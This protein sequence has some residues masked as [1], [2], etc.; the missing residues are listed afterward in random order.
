MSVGN[1]MGSNLLNVLFVV[2]ILAIFNP[3]EVEA[4][5]LQFDF[6]VMLGFCGLL[7]PIAW[8]DSQISRLGGSVLLVSFLGYLGYLIFP[9]L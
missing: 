9:Y 7:L 3:L 6:P 2:G 4:R 5:S 8:T 1:V